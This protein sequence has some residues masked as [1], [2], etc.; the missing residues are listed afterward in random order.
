MENLPN[1]I[2]SFLKNAVASQNIYTIEFEIKYD[3]NGEPEIKPNFVLKADDIKKEEFL[4]EI[5]KKIKA[6]IENNKKLNEKRLEDL[7]KK[8]ESK[9][10][11]LKK[12]QENLNVKIG[13]SL[14]KIQDIDSLM[15]INNRIIHEMDERIKMCPISEN[16][17]INQNLQNEKNA[18]K[19]KNEEKIEEIKIKK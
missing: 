12:T 17:N 19:I 9:I 13:E 4:K 16:T 10:Q 6:S 1:K 2:V 3:A 5:E 8:N 7:K 14:K 11:E 18:L 15:D